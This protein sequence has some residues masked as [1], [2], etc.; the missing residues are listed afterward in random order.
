ML[1]AYCAAPRKGH[2]EA[3]FHIFAYLKGHAKS[4]LVFNSDTVVHSDPPTLDWSDF[5]KDAQ[6]FVPPDMPEPLGE[7]VQ[8]NVFV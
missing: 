6:D 7:P 4:Q 5:Y 3:V 1:A 2:L 8:L